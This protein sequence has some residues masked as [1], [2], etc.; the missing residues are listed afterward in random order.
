[1]P[2]KYVRLPLLG[3]M[4]EEAGFHDTGAWMRNRSVRADVVSERREA[5]RWEDHEIVYDGPAF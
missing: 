4:V 1:M 5:P 2:P 3:R